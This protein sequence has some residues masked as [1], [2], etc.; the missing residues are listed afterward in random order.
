M[1]GVPIAIVCEATGPC[2]NIGGTELGT[3]FK[4]VVTYA[5]SGIEGQAHGKAPGL[6]SLR[7]PGFYHP[8]PAYFRTGRPCVPLPQDYQ[9]RVT[10]RR[11]EVLV[12]STSPD[13]RL[14]AL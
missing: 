5:A 11:W 4:P 6:V 1:T 2:H 14:D 12:V 10:V 13:P 9:R 8:A 3:E 7:G